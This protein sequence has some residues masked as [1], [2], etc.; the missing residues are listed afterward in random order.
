MNLYMMKLTQH[1]RGRA[2]ILINGIIIIEES[3]ERKVGS[4]LIPFPSVKR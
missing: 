2:G 1:K 3:S 4:D